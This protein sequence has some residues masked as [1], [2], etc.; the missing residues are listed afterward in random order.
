MKLGD[1]LRIY[2]DIIF[3]NVFRYAYEN[4][5]PKPMLTTVNSEWVGTIFNVSNI[6]NDLHWDIRDDLKN[7]NMYD[8]I[9]KYCDKYVILPDVFSMNPIPISFERNQYDTDRRNIVILNNKLFELY[10]INKKT[11]KYNHN[12]KLYYFFKEAEMEGLFNGIVENNNNFISSMYINDYGWASDRV[13][14][15]WIEKYKDDKLL[16]IFLN[17]D[18]KAS[19][20]PKDP[21]LN[22]DPNN[23]NLAGICFAY[24][25]IELD[26][27]NISLDS[28][29]DIPGHRSLGWRD[30]GMRP[31]WF[32]M[33]NGRYN[34][35]DPDSIM[36]T[37]ALVLLKD[38]TYHVE[39]LYSNPVGKY[40]ERIG[41]HNIEVKQDN[42]IKKVFMFIKPYGKNEFVKPDTTY[43]EALNKNQRAAKH[44]RKYACRTDRL[45]EYLLS[46]TCMCVD[47]I[48]KYGY[49]ND[50]DVLKVIQ[51]SFPH[52]VDLDNTAISLDKF[53]G[54]SN[55]LPE[56][57]PEV[58]AWRDRVSD[59]KVQLDLMDEH[60][61]EVNASKIEPK[62]AKYRTVWKQRMVNVE[63]KL[64]EV[65]EDLTETYIPERKINLGVDLTF[66]ISPVLDMPGKELAVEA[67]FHGIKQYSDKTEPAFFDLKS[68]IKQYCDKCGS[69]TIRS[70]DLNFKIDNYSVDYDVTIP[71]TSDPVIDQN[72]KDH[73]NN[74]FYLAKDMNSDVGDNIIDDIWGLVVYTFKGDNQDVI[75]NNITDGY[76]FYNNLN[77]KLVLDVNKVY[78]LHQIIN[79]FKNTTKIFDNSKHNDTTKIVIKMYVVPKKDGLGDIPANTL[80]KWDSIEDASTF[81][82]VDPEIITRYRTWNSN[83]KNGISNNNPSLTDDSIN[84]SGETV[85]KRIKYELERVHKTRELETERPTRPTNNFPF[86]SVVNV[87]W[88]NDGI[89]CTLTYTWAKKYRYGQDL[90]PAKLFNFK[91]LLEMFYN[92]ISTAGI[93]NVTD[94]I[95]NEFNSTST[96]TIDNFSEWDTGIKLKLSH[97]SADVLAKYKADPSMVKDAVGVSG[98]D[99][100]KWIKT[101]W[102]LALSVNSNDK[103]KTTYGFVRDFTSQDDIDEFSN[104]EISSAL[105][106]G[107]ENNYILTE[108]IDFFHIKV[109]TDGKMILD[110]TLI[111]KSA[112]KQNMQLEDKYTLKHYK[113][114]P[115][116]NINVMTYIKNQ[117]I[118]YINQLNKYNNWTPDSK[119]TQHY[120]EEVEKINKYITTYKIE[121]VSR[122]FKEQ[123][124]I[125]PAIEGNVKE[126]YKRLRELHKKREE[127]INNINEPHPTYKNLG[128]I[129]DEARLDELVTFINGFK[130]IAK[131]NIRNNEVLFI[132]NEIDKIITEIKTV[133]KVNEV[134]I[135]DILKNKLSLL[136]DI[137]HPYT[138]RQSSFDMIRTYYTKLDELIN[139]NYFYRHNNSKYN[140]IPSDYEDVFWHL[141][142][143]FHVWNPLQKYPALFFGN[144]L[145]D[146]D[147]KIIKKFDAD[148]LIVDP[149]ELMKFL[150]DENDI[151]A[152]ED[153]YYIN[154]NVDRGVDLD[155]EGRLKPYVARSKRITDPWD[156]LE[157]IEKNFKDAL[158]YNKPRIIFTDYPY[159][160]VQR[161]DG[162]IWMSKQS[163]KITRDLY[164]G[165]ACCLDKYSD[166]N[167]KSGIK[168]VNFVNGYRSLELEY[169]Y[170]VQY[171]TPIDDGYKLGPWY[172]KYEGVKFTGHTKI[173]MG[174]TD[175]Y[176]Y[177]APDI[178]VMNPVEL[179]KLTD[180]LLRDYRYIA[181]DKQGEECTDR[182]KLLS[183]DY[184]DMNFMKNYDIDGL[185]PRPSVSIYFS[186]LDDYMFDYNLNIDETKVSADN[187]GFCN[188]RVM[189]DKFIVNLFDP[190]DYWETGVKSFGDLIDYRK[191]YDKNQILLTY[192]FMDPN[193]ITAINFVIDHMR[194]IGN[195]PYFNKYADVVGQIE[196]LDHT[197]AYYI[198]DYKHKQGP[199]IK[200]SNLPAN[201][202]I[203][204]DPCVDIES[205]ITPT[206]YNE[207]VLKDADYLDMEFFLKKY[208]RGKDDFCITYNDNNGFN[209]IFINKYLIP[210][211]FKDEVWRFKD[212]KTFDNI[213]MNEKRE[214][215]DR[216][217]NNIINFEHTGSG[218][219]TIKSYAGKIHYTTDTVASID[220][221]V[222][223]LIN[224][225]INNTL[226]AD[227][228]RFIYN[229]IPMFNDT[230]KN[231]LENY[232]RYLD[233][234]HKNKLK[235]IYTLSLNNAVF[236]SLSGGLQAKIRNLLNNSHINSINNTEFITALR[237]VTNYQE[238]L[239]LLLHYTYTDNIDDILP[240]EYFNGSRNFINNI[241]EIIDDIFKDILDLI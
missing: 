176:Y 233:D 54:Y 157:W 24:P 36:T 144:R 217:I 1:N 120:V 189:S 91:N 34:I 85:R 241:K 225:I 143:Q 48:V 221:N 63:T 124:E 47:D 127:L 45:Y 218:T 166:Y 173:W 58:K 205:G 155:N 152:I 68:M 187:V 159:N 186:N 204:L 212:L 77:D 169:P 23:P 64:S 208:Y 40:V 140:I 26:Y 78:D 67:I 43:Y 158:K 82:P 145:Y 109:N 15:S 106:I 134:T 139:Y 102:G 19:E 226:S 11:F 114:L 35:Y 121:N 59:N 99:F 20:D 88:Y 230:S 153:D 56:D 122:E 79:Y 80:N 161:K 147:Y 180:K 178:S 182:V 113:K 142:Y 13:A 30:M 215:F 27:S 18:N 167:W 70:N 222:T 101:I 206:D 229:N 96:I 100:D 148:I 52:I 237:T 238:L 32:N 51:N 209:R 234:A 184:I 198:E 76:D 207:A 90:E 38:G 151:I 9:I 131:D 195:K 150:M 6:E 118:K 3:D 171:S 117:Y 224:N 213:L 123:E 137:L 188:D 200:S 2:R 10:D 164:K 170:G 130:P 179:P 29:P 89:K 133:N 86:T 223:G 194:N 41:K 16:K 154:H 66:S 94:P 28:F 110:F 211:L 95:F 177:N 65:K 240:K 74:I 75:P 183:R 108:F 37:T 7:L 105:C 112:I 50:L 62:P 174:D 22:V 210:L 199:W 149:R 39:N 160:K 201:T 129:I 191:L 4:S 202:V 42:N 232:G 165:T 87:S 44:M 116:K 25:Y 93:L 33:E 69:A 53:F 72:I 181:F 84:A 162:T 111:P 17:Q 55:K 216:A 92:N 119:I 172:S 235:H 61:A 103:L 135:S 203:S 73:A 193:D 136:K 236:N 156:D 168:G 138:L 8:D 81:T 126:V 83:I 12:G 163:G 220:R 196:V 60:I 197:N 71:F 239:D 125:E 21:I 190:V 98:V 231:A 219:Y 175:T 214:S 141:K 132:L 57:H 228:L 5:I 14:P 146:Q 185:L 104:T 128:N 107:L 31:K 46:N 192:G 227:E 49:Q 97:A 115:F